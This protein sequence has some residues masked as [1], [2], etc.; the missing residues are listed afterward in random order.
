MK[1]KFL[2][3][4]LTIFVAIIGINLPFKANAASSSSILVN[5]VPENPAPN[6]NVNINLNSYANNLDS[7]LISWSVNGK[8]ASSGIGKKTF[9]LNA[10]SAGGETSVIATISLPDGAIDT[11]ITIRPSAMVLLWQAEDSYVPPFYRG[12]ALPSAESSVKIVAMPEIKSGAGLVDP[13]NM[14]YSWKKD[15]TNNVDGS[16]Y[17]KNSFTFVN[18]Y[19]D[20]SN[21]IGV[22]A[23]T[24]D[25]KYSSQA[26][27]DVPTY[28]PK[29]IFYKNDLSLGT[30]WE[31]ALY[32][33]YRVYGNEI[34][35][36]APYFI[37]PGDIRIPFLTWSWSINDFFIDTVGNRKNLFPVQVQSGVSG[38]SII[39]VDIENKYKITGAISKELSVEF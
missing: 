7:V 2:L 36:A 8:N 29:I 11:N 18:D 1:F 33:G 37:S 23:S 6:Q 39:K 3:L 38:K 15:Y 17:G 13:R 5:M 35:E 21:N 20:D 26:N 30:L 28:S 32:D 12:K 34:I 19:L 31:N 27:I 4:Y 9:S 14:T 22:V 24:T 25:Q 10:P 16:G